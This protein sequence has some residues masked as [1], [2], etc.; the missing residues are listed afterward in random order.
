MNL[1]SIAG[2]G[3]GQRHL[4]GPQTTGREYR[5]LSEPEYAMMQDLDRG[6][7]VRDGTTLMADIFRPETDKPVPALIA[8]SVYPR[9]IQNTGAP[10][11][12]VEAG[13]TDFWVPRGY[14]H[15]IANTRGTGGS[16]GTYNW[17]DETERQ[18]MADLV[19]W[20]AAQPWCDGNVGMIGIS[21]FAMAQLAAAAER[22]EHLRAIFPVAA[23]VDVYEAVWHGTLLSET[24]INAWFAGVSSMNARNP[25]DFRSWPVEEI[26]KV[27]LLPRVHRHFEDLNGESAVNLLKKVM[28]SE[29]TQPWLDLLTQ[30]TDVHQTK[31]NWW[32]ERD[33]EPLL[34]G[35]TLPTY[36]GCDWENVPLHLPS[37]FR[38]W[39]TLSPTAPIRMGMLGAGGLTWPWES[40]HVEALAWFDHWL[41]GRDTGIM[42][43][44]P[45]RYFMPGAD[46]FFTAEQWPPADS[47]ARR[48]HLGADGTLG[49]DAQGARTFF[50]RGRGVEQQSPDLPDMVTYDTEPM[51]EDLDFAG[52]A[53][54][55]L[56]ASITAPECSWILTLQDVDPDGTLVD[57]T[58][59]W[60][61]SAR[62]GA[63]EVESVDIDLVPNA[64]RFLKGHR[65]RLVIASD[66]TSDGHPAVM[67]FRHRSTGDPS[68]NVVEATSTLELPCLQRADG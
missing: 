45:I 20:V 5:N 65:I 13:A 27:L 63:G 34:A 47:T 30:M 36:I 1:D 64:R 8:V 12:F 56:S 52:T 9:Q 24:F 22:P 53:R 17:L 40:L 21:Y 26:S 39:Q 68:I 15:V 19:E 66:D 44:P 3:A 43:G 59:G 35:S 25:K 58:A 51:S 60:H 28:K 31:D 10:L 41:K 61:R 57:V 16:G 62:V 38:L 14:A 37:T 48:W 7:P 18:D 4:N 11:G 46:E 2:N 6:I 55:T 50:H 29:L 67:G 54:V 23:T 32:I 42:E 49:P 33:M